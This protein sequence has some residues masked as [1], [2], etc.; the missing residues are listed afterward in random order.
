MRPCKARERSG[1]LFLI[2]LTERTA[3]LLALVHNPPPQ[4]EKKKNLR[5]V[6]VYHVVR[7]EGARRPAEAGPWG[8]SEGFVYRPR[9]YA[10]GMGVSACSEGVLDRRCLKTKL[11]FFIYIFL[12]YHTRSPERGLW[13]VVNAHASCPSPKQANW[14]AQDRSPKCRGLSPPALGGVTAGNGGEHASPEGVAGSFATPRRH[15][16]P[17]EAHRHATSK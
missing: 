6:R 14:Q 10:S 9:G 4:H 8:L 2:L 5:S 17:G 11:Y 15:A 12:V 16:P 3:S 1:L 13:L 7:A